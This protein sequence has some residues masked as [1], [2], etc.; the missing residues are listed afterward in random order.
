MA[1][2]RIE[3]AP[4]RMREQYRLL[5][6]LD[7]ASLSHVDKLT[8]NRITMLTKTNGR[9]GLAE[10]P[11]DARGFGKRYFPGS[12]VDPNRTGFTGGVRAE[13]PG[14][15]VFLINLNID[16]DLTTGVVTADYSTSLPL[17][18]EEYLLD[19]V[20]VVLGAKIST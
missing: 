1:Y 20:E 6:Q 11:I 8:V 9:V 15:G 13:I 5:E 14:Y 17:H 16:Y 10:F 7:V 18:Q 2:G 12:V 3:S 19:G 4:L